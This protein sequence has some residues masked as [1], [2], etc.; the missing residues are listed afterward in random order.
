M[1]LFFPND[2]FYN[3]FNNKIGTV[4]Y[5]R[6]DTR[7]KYMRNINFSHYYYHVHYDDGSFETYLYQNDM[8]QL[9][10][11]YEQPVYFE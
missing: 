4:K 9:K 8:I 3:K 10:R 11:L 1:Q 2:R 5:L 6:D 7:E